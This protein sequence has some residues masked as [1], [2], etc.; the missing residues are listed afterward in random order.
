ME[1]DV[2]D[3]L[4]NRFAEKYPYKMALNREVPNQPVQ[5]PIQHPIPHP[6]HVTHSEQPVQ[7]TSTNEQH[8]QS[9]QR[10]T[11]NEPTVM[12]YDHVSQSKSEEEI[13]LNQLEQLEQ[14][15]NIEFPSRPSLNHDKGLSLNFWLFV[16][17][18]ILIV[19]IVFYLIM[20]RR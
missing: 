3:Q 5:E 4:I 20:K 15:Q 2:I 6:S 16:V 14:L 17:L 10:E 19:G 9:V 1:Q 12:D 8:V 18:I 7:S 13:L 11:L